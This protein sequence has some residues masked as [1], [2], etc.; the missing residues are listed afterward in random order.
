MV[1][2]LP[3]LTGRAGIGRFPAVSRTAPVALWY[4][5]YQDDPGLSAPRSA[6]D[7]G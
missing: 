4:W 3:G 5:P 1:P 2:G 7:L 6:V